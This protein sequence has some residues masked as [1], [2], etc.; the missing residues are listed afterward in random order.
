MHNDTFFMKFL[1]HSVHVTR[2][3]AYITLPK[4]M[5]VA[6]RFRIALPKGPNKVCDRLFL[7]ERM[8]I[9]HVTKI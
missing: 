3:E 1:L 6:H 9:G 7:Y 2:Y 8:G 4:V 5:C